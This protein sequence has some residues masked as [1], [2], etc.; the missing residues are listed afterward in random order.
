[1]LLFITKVTNYLVIVNIDKVREQQKL[2]NRCN[3]L[4]IICEREMFPFKNDFPKHLVGVS[5]S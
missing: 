3:S 5:P 4:R 1:M 2:Q